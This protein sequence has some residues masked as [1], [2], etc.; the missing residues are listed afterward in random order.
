VPCTCIGCVTIGGM[1]RIAP[2]LL[3]SLLALPSLAALA[4]KYEEWGAGPV[5]WIMTS[6]EKRTWR[7]I[8]SDAEAVKFIDLF[9]DEFDSRVTF[10]DQ[11]FLE[12][13]KRGA[14]TDRGR[15][16]IVLGPATRTGSSTR[17][18]N[19][20]MGVGSADGVDG[21]AGRRRG[22]RE[23]WFWEHQDAEKFDMGKVE[24]AFIEDITANRVQLDPHKLDFGRAEAIAIRKAIV[25]P[26]MT[27]VPE[28][29]ATGG[30]QPVGR[31]VT[32]SVPD[33]TPAE[34]IEKPAATPEAVLTPAVASNE[35]G[36][37]SVT[38]GAGGA[39][40]VPYCATKADL[41]KLKFMLVINGPLEGG[42]KEQVTRQQNARL[43]PL[44]AQPNCYALRGTLPVSKLAPGRY[45]VSVLIDDVVTQDTYTVKGEYRVQ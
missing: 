40:V 16:F 45:R 42:A 2:L 26:Q 29:A 38:F 10:A 30:L 22:A 41:P 36:A 7:K 13:R 8:T 43:E 32:N 33:P 27:A 5:Q 17:E 9:W 11:T 44:P 25:N 3:L 23:S 12:K 4:P 37:S 18:S 34:A 15:V 6:D 1:R 28:W 14:L 20:E 39:W 21:A 31:A 24:V 19:A 35:P